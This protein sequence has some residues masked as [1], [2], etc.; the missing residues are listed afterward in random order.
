MGRFDSQSDRSGKMLGPW[1]L[2][3]P[4]VAV[5]VSVGL[6]WVDFSG[7][8]GGAVVR[9]AMAA[10]APPVDG[11]RAYTY[12]EE[13]CKIGPRTAGSKANER[14]RLMVEKHFEK[15]GGV[16]SRQE[17]KIPHPRT[18][19]MLTLVNLIGS[20]NPDKRERVVI[21]A[22]Y[23]TRPFADQEDDPEHQDKPF[24]GANDGASGVALL[25]EIAHHLK[26]M[27]T[28]WGVDLVLFDAEELVYGNR[29]NLVGEYFLGSK[30]FAKKYR[31]QATQRRPQYR[32]DY[33]I[34]LD[35]V[36]GTN[37]Q[38]GQEP[39][40][41]EYA[42]RLVEH[43]WAV[44]QGLRIRSFRNQ[45][46]QEVMDDHLPLNEVGIPTVDLIDF[47][48]PHWHRITDTP[49]NCSPKSLEDVGRVITMWLS[50]PAAGGAPRARRRR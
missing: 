29:D 25:M 18:R 49:E 41:V 44:A 33:G 32:Y 35:M 50:Q 21:G 1:L 5:V 13:I 3:A 24:I 22:H 17:W 15:M 27:N 8:G 42:P 40:S 38:I 19:Q 23:D 31:A 14:Q 36:G 47:T 12:L 39:K 11:K 9:G 46:S 7:E 43:L 48:Y 10:Q 26:N 45:F 34:V 28:P 30:Q 16:I 4:V 2:L 37:L 20:W 6:C